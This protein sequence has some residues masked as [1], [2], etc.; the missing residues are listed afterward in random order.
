MFKRSAISLFIFRL[1]I[2]LFCISGNQPGFAGESGKIKGTVVDVETAE[3]LPDVTVSIYWLGNSNRAHLQTR[4]DANGRY[5]IVNIPVGQYEIDFRVDGYQAVRTT[6]VPVYA[7]QATMV[8]F[9]LTP[10]ISS[11]ISTFVF[12]RSAILHDQT[13]TIQIATAEDMAMLPLRDYRD[14]LSLQPGLTGYSI[15]KTEISYPAWIKSEWIMRGGRVGEIDYR[16]N[17]IS[18]RDPLTGL[19]N[20]PIPPQSIQQMTIMNSGFSAEYGRVMSGVVNMIGQ[21][22]SNEYHASIGAATDNLVGSGYDDNNYNFSVSGPIIPIGLERA[23]YDLRFF[24]SGQRIW[25]ADRTPGQNFPKE[26]FEKV[27]GFETLDIGD[28]TSPGIK[29]HYGNELDLLKEGKKPHNYRSHKSWYGRIDLDISHRFKVDLTALSVSEKWRQYLHEYA[30]N[31]EHTPYHEDE[32]RAWSAKIS[33]D[34]SRKTSFSIKGSYFSSERF[35]GDGVH[36]QDLLAYGR[37]SRPPGFDDTTLFWTWDDMYGPTPFEYREFE[38]ETDN[39]GEDAATWDPVSFVVGG[40]E[41]TLYN[42]YLK[43]KS[44]KV[45]LSF[46]IIS[47]IHPNH[48]VKAGFDMLRQN[49]RYYRNLFPNRSY[50]YLQG[51]E[52]GDLD[53]DRYGYWFDPRL[54]KLV[55]D[56]DPTGNG[57]DG[58][59]KPIMRAFYIQDLFEYQELTLNLGLRYDYLDVNTPRLV[60]PDNPFQDDFRF[61]DD[62]LIEKPDPLTAISP[63]LGIG[64]PIEEHTVLHINYGH[65]YQ[66]P[67]PFYLYVSYAYLE[68]K[69]RRG[70]YFYPFGNPNLEWEKTIAYEVA[71]RHQM[72]PTAVF[73]V[74]AYYKSMKDL[75]QIR[76]FWS[77]PEAHSSYR[78]N[79][80][81]AVKGLDFNLQT[82]RTNNL[83]TNL[84]YSLS[85]ANGT[86][87]NPSSTS[88]IAWQGEEEPGTLHP[89][90]FDQRHQFKFDVD[91]RYQNNAPLPIL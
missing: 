18:L 52:A 72:S 43:H 55:E 3:P 67:N 65:F 8:D 86:G 56:D 19:T 21:S 2:I 69:I 37:L 73:E 20:V 62:D 82:L 40:D 58:P 53:V 31:L 39:W 23:G 80:R 10:G 14:V 7:D 35:R 15:E 9:Q 4:T 71:V 59:K 91:Y 51:Q 83:S 5:Y 46:D 11:E 88:N 63:R 32:T 79:D 47:R 49:L 24:F 6:D 33:Y 74:T 87:S 12:K 16:F 48:E 66:P 38:W 84:A 78:N 13:A 90:D 26:Y 77:I 68:S 34:L 36:R 30:F 27:A 17:G 42:D 64:F 75:T 54:N 1:A 22:G 70:G 44:S 41:A 81:G 76:T 61:D 29:N 85:W 28:S 60:S 25:Q 57:L 89:L 45:D 50:C